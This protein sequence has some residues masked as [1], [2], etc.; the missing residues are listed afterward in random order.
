MRL[1]LGDVEHDLTTHALVMGALGGSPPVVG[2]GDVAALDRWLGRAEA[3]VREGAD[4]LDV[5][6]M[7]AGP[8]PPVGEQEELDGV[9]PAVQALRARL[10]VPLAVDT[11]RARVLA[12]SCAAGATAGRD[13]SGFVDPEYLPV[14]AHAGATVIIPH[15]RLPGG[16]E[17]VV[18]EVRS[19]LAG[20]IVRA[21]GSGIADER[22][23]VDAGLGLGK[24]PAQSL[25][26]LRELAG[27]A[28]LGPA[29]LVSASDRRLL[30]LDPDP[31]ARAQRTT[32]HAAAALAVARG[33]RIVRAS[34]VRGAKRVTDVLEA[35]LTARLAHVVGAEPG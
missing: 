19:S 8:G 24:S 2:G 23:I 27:L 15:T 5:G 11:W 16:A 21:N 34:D 26:L 29:V 17:D 7:G 32:G 30:D 35:L 14:A 22:I 28:D 1:R 4:L 31:D 18:A 12:E 3:M 9:V 33:C 10:D 6:G 20:L 25:T 13:T